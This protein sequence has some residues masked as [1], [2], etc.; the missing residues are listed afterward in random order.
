MLVLGYEYSSLSLGPPQ[1]G[2]II[3]AQRQITRVPHLYDIQTIL[4]RVVV[5]LYGSEE[6]CANVLVEEKGQDHDLR[7]ANTTHGLESFAELR[8]RRTL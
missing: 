7:A 1:N 3:T 4:A 2:W 5:A 8:G 6:T